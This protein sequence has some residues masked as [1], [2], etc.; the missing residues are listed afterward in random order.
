MLLRT[1][2]SLVMLATTSLT[3]PLLAMSLLAMSLLT[4]TLDERTRSLAGRLPEAE[5]QVV[6]VR[7]A[8]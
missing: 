1:P 3:P 7:W 5:R 2:P 8:S 6:L 4:L